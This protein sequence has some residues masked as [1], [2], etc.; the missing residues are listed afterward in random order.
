MS[1]AKRKPIQYPGTGFGGGLLRPREVVDA[2]LAA[3]SRQPTP[4]DPSANPTLS[5]PAP[6]VAVE[7]R[8]G[9]EEE[10]RKIGKVEKRTETTTGGRRPGPTKLGD[11][12]VLFDEDGVRLYDVNVKADRKDSFFFTTEEFDELARVKL[13]LKTKHRLPVIKD[14]IARCAFNLL[15]QDYRERGEASVLVQY[16]RLKRAK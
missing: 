14:D 12:P 2:E 5:D 10:K 1:N 11:V 16:L 7:K 3:E 4:D 6:V 9:G 8:I 13:E 15:L